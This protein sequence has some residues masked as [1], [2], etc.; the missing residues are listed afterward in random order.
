MS[1][2]LL[3]QGQTKENKR[4]KVQMGEKENMFTNK[5]VQSYSR[6]TNQKI[7]WN[8]FKKFKNLTKYV[9]HAH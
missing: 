5:K 6:L 2:D 8:K 9:L 4:G 7:I 3:S 1:Q